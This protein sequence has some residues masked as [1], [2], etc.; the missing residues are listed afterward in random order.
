MVGIARIAEG[1]LVLLFVST[2]LEKKLATLAKL[3]LS[4]IK[5]ITQVRGVCRSYLA[6]LFLIEN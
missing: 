1:S 4:K 6:Y 3:I 5:S 2:P